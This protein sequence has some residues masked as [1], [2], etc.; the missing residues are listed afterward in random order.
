MLFY[1]NNFIYDPN[2]LVKENKRFLLLKTN[3]LVQFIYLLK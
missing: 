3:A 2:F 1:F